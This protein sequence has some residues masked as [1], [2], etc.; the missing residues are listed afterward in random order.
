MR[1]QCIGVWTL[2]GAWSAKELT[3]GFVPESVLKEYGGTPKITALLLD[4]G[5]WDIVEGGI[6]F[7][8]WSKWQQK[9]DKILARR[10]EWAQRQRKSR[11]NTGQPADQE[12]SEM[13]PRDSRVSHA[14]VTHGVTRESPSPFPFPSNSGTYV[15]SKP[16]SSTGAGHRKPGGREQALA[17]IQEANL[18]ARSLDAYRIAKAFSDSLPVPI[19]TNLLAQV[20][21]EI[22]KCL[23]SDIPPPAIALGL[24]AWVESD[25]WSP[26]QINRFVLKSNSRIAK[27]GKPTAKA[28][29][30]DEALA[31]LLQEVET[32]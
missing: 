24:R 32:A 10:A 12:Q 31:E 19:E 8:N 9:K 13:S 25:S 22:D 30:Y 27:I 18:T 1:P 3:D 23:K 16:T 14:S 15:S 20:G 7:R 29:S 28:L 21:V 6:I 11:R 4:A 26:T 5:L 17:R 2:C